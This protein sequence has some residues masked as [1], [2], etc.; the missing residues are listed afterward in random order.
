MSAKSADGIDF[1]EE[2]FDA[3]FRQVTLYKLSEVFAG[4]RL[5]RRRVFLH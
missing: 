4:F 5:S 2:K 1:V 3:Y